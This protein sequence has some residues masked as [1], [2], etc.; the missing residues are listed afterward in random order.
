MNPF[1]ALAAFAADWNRLSGMLDAEA[2]R[3]LGRSLAALRE[4]ASPEAASR[5]ADADRAAAAGRAARSV[6]DALPAHEAGRLRRDGDGG[7]FTGAPPDTP[8]AG[9][10]AADLCMLVLDGNPMV[11]P[12]L[13]AVR[14][15]LLGAPASAWVEGTDPRLIALSGEDGRRRVP[16]FQFEAGGMP[17]RVVLEVNT[18]LRADA[19]PWGVA[20]WWLSPTTWWR[21]TPSSLLGRGRDGELLG[22]ARAL[23]AAGGEE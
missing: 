16:G 5:E 19:D 23:T 14:E 18:L 1:I 10:T 12:V 22:A 11:G 21:G 8:Y 6:L 20:D 4:T 2:H 7:R 17:W 15:R 13:G 9:F 3:A